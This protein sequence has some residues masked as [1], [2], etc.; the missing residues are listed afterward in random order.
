[1]RWLSTELV[2]QLIHRVIDYQNRSHTN[3]L[4]RVMV[5][6]G[7]RAV[8]VDVSVLETVFVVVLLSMMSQMTSFA[9][10][11]GAGP[12]QMLLD[13]LLRERRMRALATYSSRF[14]LYTDPGSVVSIGMNPETAPIVFV[15]VVVVVSVSV[16]VEVVVMVVVSAVWVS[17][18]VVESVI[19]AVSCTVVSSDPHFSWSG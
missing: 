6:V 18:I 10:F 14:R 11:G 1:M 7:V 3:V 8:L 19:V 12:L 13:V 16:D 9:Y 17:V 5:V 2:S 4:V 15:E